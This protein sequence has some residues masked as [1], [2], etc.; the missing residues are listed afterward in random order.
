MTII[1]FRLRAGGLG[2][3]LLTHVKKLLYLILT[4]DTQS[5]IILPSSNSF[6]Q[7]CQERI[8][9]WL[10]VGDRDTRGWHFYCTF[11]VKRLPRT[12]MTRR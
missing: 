11:K 4:G 8:T 2:I 7:I 5:F 6:A 12:Q 9:R 3:H 1:C 10:R